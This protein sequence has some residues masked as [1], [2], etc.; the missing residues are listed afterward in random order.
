MRFIAIYNCLWVHI[1]AILLSFAEIAE[2]KMCHPKI[3]LPFLN[4]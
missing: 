3:Y 4:E 1:F 2:I